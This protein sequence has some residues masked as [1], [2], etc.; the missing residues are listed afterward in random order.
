MKKILNIT[1][2]KFIKISDKQLLKDKIIREC[3][4][5]TLKGTVLISDKGINLSIA[6]IL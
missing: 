2:Y 4:L 5:L 6:G 1:G 3:N